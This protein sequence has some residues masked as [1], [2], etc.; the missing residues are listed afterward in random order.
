[1]IGRRMTEPLRP[2]VFLDRDG[3]VIREREYLS[4][5]A[6]VV[7][8]P[9]AVGALTDFQAAGYAVVV[10]TNQ[11]GIARGYYD[12]GA[13][14]AVE[15]EVESQLRDAGVRVLASYHCPHHPEITG[16]CECRKPAV[17]LF[18]QAAAEHGLDL[19]RSVYIGDRVRDV[20]PALELGGRGILVRTGYGDGEADAAPPG[21]AVVD[22]LPGAAV[23]AGVRSVGL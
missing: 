11:S 22:D 5:P 7:L 16:A 13:Y 6:A 18:R 8:L 4:D 3:T 10:V 1:M 17:G 15:A 2:A 19:S 23:A 14:R 21:V 9:G 20:A 12:A